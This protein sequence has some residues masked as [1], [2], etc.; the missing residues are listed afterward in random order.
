ME[1]K[2]E[3]KR[4]DVFAT[5]LGG[6]LGTLIKAAERVKSQD[7]EAKYSHAGVIIDPTGITLEALWTFKRQNLFEAYSGSD[8][9]IARWKDMKLYNFCKGLEALKKCEGSWYPVHRLFLHL[10]GLGKINVDRWRVC[11][12][13]TSYFQIV[14]I[15]A[16]KLTEGDNPYGVTPDNL[17]DE[18][19]Q[20]KHCDVIFEGKLDKEKFD[21]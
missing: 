13:Q 7:S 10:L 9:V 3:L 8:V 17:V 21:A 16:N 15:G 12:E 20:S 14:A 5:N 19:R 11:S 6:V 4:G 1:K 2:I 18:W